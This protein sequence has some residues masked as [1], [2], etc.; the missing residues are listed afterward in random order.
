MYSCFS[1]WSVSLT[2]RHTRPL[3]PLPPPFPLPAILGRGKQVGELRLMSP[4][5][6]YYL[7]SMCEETDSNTDL[8]RFY[9]IIVLF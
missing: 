7:Y 8:L 3:W 9:G 1:I 2:H 6:V 4:F 5:T